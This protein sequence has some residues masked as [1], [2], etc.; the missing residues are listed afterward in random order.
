[1]VGH[2]HPADDHVAISTKADKDFVKR[3]D[4]K[5]IIFPVKNFHSQTWKKE[6]HRQ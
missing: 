2:L 5:Y 3:L 1:M 6:F 4:F